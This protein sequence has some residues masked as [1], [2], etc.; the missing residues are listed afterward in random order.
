VALAGT[1]AA[2]AKRAG[3]ISGA[4]ADALERTASAYRRLSRAALNGDGPAFGRA[5]RDVEASEAAVA[6][7]LRDSG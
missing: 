2:S 1:Y 7:A 6:R 5:R 3:S 4:L